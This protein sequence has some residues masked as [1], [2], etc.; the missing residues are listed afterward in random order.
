MIGH[1][2]DTHLFSEIDRNKTKSTSSGSESDHPDCS[3]TYVFHLWVWF[4]MN[5]ENQRLLPSGWW[6]S[7]RYMHSL[8]LPL[9]LRVRKRKIMSDFSFQSH[10]I[11]ILATCESKTHLH[12]T[13]AHWPTGALSVLILSDILH[14]L[15]G[16]WAPVANTAKLQFSQASWSV[17]CVHVFG[18]MCAHVGTMCSFKNRH[19]SGVLVVDHKSAWL[20]LPGASCQSGANA[21][22][23]QAARTEPWWRMSTL[24]SSVTNQSDAC[25]LLSHK[26]GCWLKAFL[27]SASLKCG[28][29]GTGHGG[30]ILGVCRKPG[31]PVLRVDLWTLEGCAESP[32]TCSSCFLT[33]WHKKRG[34][35]ATVP[36]VLLL[37]VYQGLI[38]LQLLM[39]SSKYCTMF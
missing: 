5:Y 21:E 12:C 10:C 38:Y 11:S 28:V 36:M 19:S 18:G 26:R 15:R 25:L 20:C 34:V 39:H 2:Y 33:V 1:W 4:L 3:A 24:K 23:T 22:Q 35:S 32:P 16:S 27:R 37:P 6:R 31:D 8:V 9:W 30:R 17:G 13:P 14:W 7:I 29:S